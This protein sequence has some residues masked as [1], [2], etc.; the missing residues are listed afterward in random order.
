[1]PNVYWQGV[2]TAGPRQ[3][4]VLLRSR[5]GCTARRARCAR[6]RPSTP[7]IP[8]SVLAAEGYNHVGD[9]GYQGGRA[10]CCRSSA[11]RRAGRTAATPAARLRSASADPSTLAFQYYVKL[12]P[13]EIPK[14]M[15]VEASPDG[16]LLWTS[17][18]NDLLAYRAADVNPANAAPGAQPI[19][20]VRRLA[21]AVPPSGV[22]GAAFHRG[23]LFLAGRA[24]HD[25]PGVVGGRRDRRAPARAGASERPGRGRG[26]RRD[27]RC[28][29]AGSTSWSRRWPPS[30]PS[31]RRSG[32]CTSPRALG[33][34]RPVA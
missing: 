26:P 34:A 9:I 7:S 1:M 2:T 18:G 24:G 14:A 3:A 27:P 5:N 8:P 28:S 6:P 12:D 15:W 4:A 20:A 16:Q 11:T 21:G 29:A 31:A 23:R 33:R 32:C 22:T 13:A 17:S 30:R 19:H 25:L 10:C